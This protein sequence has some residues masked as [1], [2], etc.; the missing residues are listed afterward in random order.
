MPPLIAA[1]VTF[2]A[3]ASWTTIAFTV[4]TLA[5]VAYSAYML[6]TLEKPGQPDS[7]KRSQTVRSS[8]QPHRVIYGEVMTG[9]VLVYAQSHSIDPLTLEEKEGDNVYISLVVAFCAHE[10]EEIKEVWLNEKLSTDATFARH[11]ETVPA[12]G[13]NEAIY[14]TDG[15]YVGQT[16]I[17]TNPE[18][19]AHDEPYVVV[20]KYTGTSDQVADP[21]LISL[22]PQPSNI[23]S[24]FPTTGLSDMTVGGT[25]SGIGMTV[26]T[27]TITATGAADTFEVRDDDGNV[28][29]S[30]I[31]GLNQGLAHDIWI[32]FAA[33][34]GHS[35]GQTWEV[36]AFDGAPWTSEC[37]LTGRA[38]VIVTLQKHD[39]AFP[40]GLPNIKALIRGN[41][42]IHDPRTEGTTNL[43]QSPSDMGQ[44]PW[45]TS[46]TSYSSGKLTEL[47]TTPAHSIAQSVD[48]VSGATY[49]ASIKAKAAER[50]VIFITMLPAYFGPD[51]NS[52]AV[53]DLSNG[54][55]AASKGIPSITDIGDGEYLCSLTLPAIATGSAE[56][57]YFIST[58]YNLDITTALHTGVVGSGAYLREPQM[59]A[60]DNA[61]DYVDG[62]RADAPGYTDNFALCI[63][64]YLTKPYGLGCP[65]ADINDTA[66]IAAANIC[67][68][69]VT[70]ADGTTQSRYT[71]NGSF[72]VDKTPTAI[73]NEM[74]ATAYGAITWT[75]G[76]YRILPAS[77]YTPDLTFH[78]VNV[79]VP[80]LT[81][82]DLRGPIK[83]RPMPSMKDR[84]NT[85]K[86]TYISPDTWQ[87][88]DFPKVTNALYV[89]QDGG[90]VTKD[91]QLSYVTDS[92]RAQRIA[93]IILEKGR[94][95]ILVEFPA[96][97]SA[98][99]LA[100][101]DTVPIS[102]SHLG[103]VSKIFTVRDWRMNPDGGVDLTLQEDA[104]GCYAWNNGEETTV[105]L[106]QNTILPDPGYVGTIAS[107]TVG[108]ELYATNVGSIIK[109]RAILTWDAM[110]VRQYEAHYL[111]PNNTI[112][113]T[114]PLTTNTTV[115]VDDTIPGP[116]SFRVRA[117]NYL[118]V[119]SE[120]A[121][122]TTTIYGKAYPPSDVTGFDAVLT[123]GQM[124]MSWTPITDLDAYAYEIQ[125][126]TVWG[127]ASNTVLVTNYVGSSYPWTPTTSGDID[128]LIKAIDTTGNYSTN[129]AP[130]TYTI[131]APGPVTS[132]TQSV[133][134]NIVELHWTAGTVGS[135]PIEYYELWKGTTFAGA[136]LI[137]RKYGTFDLLS[138]SVAGT[139]KYWV[140]TVDVA[141]LTS[142]EVGVY[143][144]V[145]QP[146]DYVLI[147]SQELDFAG[148]TLTNA[149]IENDNVLLPVNLTITW[150]DHFQANPDTLLEP[151]ASPQDQ[152]DDGLTMF[153]QPGPSTGTIEDVIDY[154]ATIPQSQLTM[155]VT[156]EA[157][158]GTVT[159]TPEILIST[160]NVDWTS[161]GN[162]YES[163][164][165]AFRYVKY[166]LVATTSD[167][168]VASVSQI[169]VKLDVKQKT[170]VT[171]DID[172]VDTTGD[173]TEFL[174]EDLGIAPADVIGIT[175]DAPW[176]NSGT[177]DPIKALINFTD[178]PNPTSFKVLAWNK[179]GTRVAVNNV[180]VTIRYI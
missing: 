159:F 154:G 125:L 123:R 163:M 121:I 82:S 1:I 170:F 43:F 40:N 20:T 52:H 23:I 102:I 57:R 4:V 6:S 56:V 104:E 47:V 175:A 21:F 157:L 16:W 31:T 135:F 96:K 95:G 173:G 55:C 180:T 147:S 116:Y 45:S 11:L 29:T 3:V 109:S 34:T 67:D 58:T 162:V 85:V 164:A 13:Y 36:R 50:D 61:T 90:E 28:G 27:I 60:N 158:A 15:D 97:W 44:A 128:L 142:S 25:Y 103:W 113:A 141:G 14:N 18:V 62:T 72:T 53:F 149:V 81:E 101:G 136:E 68:E 17:E 120:W 100:V 166:R 110:N 126:G 7:V 77:Y 93:K 99:P 88:V 19:P 133:I 151:W 150:E 51:A 160:N 42:Q 156:R 65:I 114:L 129:A 124:L 79:G 87:P 38:Y 73:M 49:T 2:I 5:A 111:P 165:S 80:G 89:S 69:E 161:L 83:V 75:Q 130:L 139:Y 98:F 143:A 153:M 32:R 134:D 22:P 66:A 176:T 155:S 24:K 145:S 94:Q 112:W 106:A 146:P 168:G 127:D 132:L 140:R 137:G 9:G 144:T 178:A 63:R 172:V 78:G 105:D 10:V 37:T 131:A 177:N 59:E 84:F 86:G 48:V 174:F 138:E 117:M 167:G 35:V 108:E 12:E 30:D 76:Q 71:M 41:N 46:G 26:Y 152:V 179:S 92:A 8:V 64:D 171:N 122:L 169:N 115:T 39:E 118:G 54:V 70:L 119:W 148:S 74:L 33:V 91:I 107:L